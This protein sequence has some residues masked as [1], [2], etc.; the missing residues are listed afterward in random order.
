MITKI[1]ATGSLG[2]LLGY[3]SGYNLSYSSGLIKLAILILIINLFFIK[4]SLRDTNLKI[5]LILSSV[6]ILFFVVSN[7]R[8]NI[9]KKEFININQKVNLTVK[10]Y[11]VL[12]KDTTKVIKAEILNINKLNPGSNET[13]SL[14]G[15]EVKEG[16]SFDA[17]NYLDNSI[18]LRNIVIYTFSQ[19]KYEPGTILELEGVIKNELIILP[20]KENET[21]FDEN[22]GKSFNLLKYWNTKNIDLVS[23]Y[24]KLKIINNNS[25]I[26]SEISSEK[27]LVPELEIKK[28]SNEDGGYLDSLQDKIYLHSYIFRNYFRE[29]LNKT[30]DSFDTGIIMAMLWGDENSISRE[31]KNIFKNTGTSHILVL[32]GY[33]LIIV[34]AFV[35]F[36]FR[37][38]PLKKK[39]IISVFFIIIF[40][41][42]AQTSA[43]VWRA[44][45]MSL[46]TMLTIFFLKEAN[47]KLALWLTSFVFFIYSPTVAM[48]DISFH[49]SFLATSGIIY[50]YPELEI[51]IKSILFTKKEIIKIKNINKN[52]K[53]TFELENKKIFDSEKYKKYQLLIS[54]ILITISVNIL[55][56]PY[57]IFQFGYF[58][59]SAILFSI[60]VTPFVPLI[61]LFGFL[62]GSVNIFVNLILSFD[63]YIINIFS[64]IILLITKSLSFILENIIGFIF[65][66]LKTF[67][68]SSATISSGISFTNFII[69]YLFIVLFYFYLKFINKN[70]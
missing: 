46:Y 49:L 27:I 36:L 20:K 2:M 15:L 34:A 37:N 50:F 13:K 61:M 68:E 29:S 7:I 55:I 25:E 10:V 8:G 28:D 30:L 60:L 41:L 51:L 70:N 44:S 53:E 4:K 47:A 1:L 33:N 69:L 43:P 23:M 9:L 62:I 11:D 58:K 12:I 59:I 57:L 22:S 19:E 24:P 67:S 42:L 3:L 16:E 63:I 21:H 52:H 14:E 64:K 39:M 40:L 56:A 38:F 17:E 35:S 66:I 18:I 5:I 6:F 45:V 32:S 65:N 54:A 48:Y 31:T 26:K